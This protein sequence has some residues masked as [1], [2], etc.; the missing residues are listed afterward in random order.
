[1]SQ[2]EI[3]FLNILPKSEMAVLDWPG[4]SPDLHSTQNLWSYISNKV[5]EKHPSS[6]AKLVT[7]IK[8]VKEIT[9]EYCAFSVKTMLRSLGV[10]IREKGV[11]TKY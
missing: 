8:E 4:N 5:A 10:V 9:S 2:I 3:W 7:A 1:M 6:V 11:H